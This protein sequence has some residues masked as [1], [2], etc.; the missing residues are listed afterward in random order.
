MS[1]SE[2]KIESAAAEQMAETIFGEGVKI[3]SAR[4]SGAEGQ[5]GIY[6]GANETMPGV[7][8]ADRGLILSTGRVS[9]FT[10]SEGDANISE[11]TST[12]LM[13]AGD[14]MLSRVSGQ[15]TFDAA[16]FEASFVPTGDVLTMQIVWSSEEYLEYVNSG[17]ND[18]FAVWVNDVPAELVLGAGSISIDNINN[19]VNSNLYIDNAAASNTYNTEMD[20]FTVTLTLKVPV[21]AGE[22]NTFRM[23][24]ADSGDGAFDSAVMVAAGSVQV[25]LIALDDEM[26]I[27]KG[28]LA[29][30]D[31]LGNDKSS[32]GAMLKVTKINGIAVEAGDSVKLP[33]GEVITLGKDGVLYVES[34]DS[35]EDRVL[36]YEVTDSMG[37]TDV[38][39][40]T[41][42]MVACFTEGTLIDVP[43]GRVA[44][45]RLV[46]GDLVLTRDHGAQALRWVGRVVRAAQGEDAPVEI[47]AGTLGDHAAVR[48]SPN[49]RVLVAGARAELL[50]G[51]TEVLVKAKHLVDGRAVRVVEGGEVAYLHLLFDR[52][53]VVTANGLP[54]ESYFPGDQAMAAFDADAQNEI[55]RLF[56][57]LRDGSQSFG[58]LARA[59]VNGREARLLVH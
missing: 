53:E 34:V 33:T 54:C 26:S 30:L 15:T 39:F 16:V 32:V 45:E 31:V 11:G 7:A 56:P 41:L 22:V 23:A 10:R 18:A 1:A 9:D 52:H 28:D 13:G 36:T 40:V 51:E 5:V 42:S 47:A 17:F 43:R 20:G 12:N 14:E 25:G 29:K 4:Y 19:K 58:Q 6:S 59:E 8:P 35:L 2:L 49:H 37:N 27:R 55:L 48:L 50:F 46:P 24:I 38:A 44:V 21:R 57:M 3:V